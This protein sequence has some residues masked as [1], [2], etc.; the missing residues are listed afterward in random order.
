MPVVCLTGAT[1]LIGAH[2]CQQLLEQGHEV[3]AAVRDPS[4]KK[5]DFLR[6]MAKSEKCA[7]GT[8]KLFKADLTVRGS[9]EEAMKGCSVVIHTAAVVQ[10][11][12]DRCP[13]EEVIIP[14]VE[15]SRDIAQTAKKAGIKRFINTGSVSSILQMEENREP[16][17]RG[18]PFCEEERRF[19]L[20]PHYATYQHAKYESEQVV[21][22]EFDQGEVISIL[23]CWTMG[24]Q[25]HPSAT[26]SH[27]L[28]RTLAARE[29]PMAPLFYTSWCSVEDV[30][31]AHVLAAFCKMPEGHR[32]RRYII[33]QG[34]LVMAQDFSDSIAKQFKHL[35]PPSRTTPWALLWLASF[36]DKRLGPFVLQEKCVKTPPFD[37]TRITKELGFQYQ[38]TQLDPVIKRAIDSMIQH[39]NVAAPPKS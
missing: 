4:S 37:G 36:K 39:G 6:D 7:K 28:I 12:F 21:Y 13:F 8:L 18:K 24:Q 14:A 20:R 10:M 11:H 9:Y 15:G 5:C 26:S 31:A 19:D 27:A 1:G 22:K 17:F 34:D 16:R 33:S 35:S 2:I 32:T 23:P 29:L 25:L 30:A 38:H 3:H